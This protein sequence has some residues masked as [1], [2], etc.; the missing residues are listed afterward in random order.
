MA[1]VKTLV[2]GLQYFAQAQEVSE[3]NQLIN[4]SRQAH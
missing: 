1:Q 2:L 3:Q 4:R